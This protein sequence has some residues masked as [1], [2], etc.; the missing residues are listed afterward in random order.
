M[1][2]IKN[3]DWTPRPAPAII[4][5][6][7]ER[8]TS[9]AR[10]VVPRR[11][12][13]LVG[14]AGIGKSYLLARL[15]EAATREGKRV[16]TI[17]FPTPLADLT[18]RFALPPGSSVDHLARTLVARGGIVFVDCGPDGTLGSADGDR[19][20]AVLLLAR[21]AAENATV[22]AARRALPSASALGGIAAS[23]DAVY[24]VEPLGVPTN[25]APFSVACAA[26]S[27]A[28]FLRVHSSFSGGSAGGIPLDATSLRGIVSFVRAV[29]GFP[30]PI[31]A[32]ARRLAER[33]GG[34]AITERSPGWRGHGRTVAN[35]RPARDALEFAFDPDADAVRRAHEAALR[36]ALAR[37]SP[38][39]R[40]RLVALAPF[41]GGDAAA[42]EDGAARFAGLVQTLAD[43]RTRPLAS[44]RRVL[45]PDG[46][47]PAARAH[48]VTQIANRFENVGDASE[49]LRFDARLDGEVRDD[50]ERAFLWAQELELHERVAPLAIVVARMALGAGMA[51]D[52]VR[53]LEAAL[54][55]G[56][57]APTSSR[58]ASFHQLAPAIS[59][60]LG[61]ARIFRG[62]SAARNDLRNA[63]KEGDRH[64]QA[65][66]IAYRGLHEG[67]SDDANRGLALVQRAFARAAAPCPPA[68][69]GRILKNEANL[70]LEASRPAEL[71]LR[72][73]RACFSA[74]GDR[75]EIAF[76]DLIL[77][78]VLCDEGRF[79]EANE[80]ARAAL[81]VFRRLGDSR[82]EGRVRH[83][84]G[85][86]AADGGDVSAAQGH[87]DDAIDRFRAT[88]DRKSE[89]QSTASQAALAVER[90][91]LSAARVLVD[92]ALALFD[93]RDEPEQAL[94]WA[95]LG[96]L[97]ARSGR[98]S[99]AQI[100]FGRA[101]KCA[102]G[103]T[104]T[105][106]SDAVALFARIFDHPES[107][108]TA[109]A[110]RMKT[111][112]REEVRLAW[113]I[114]GG[115]AP[116]ASRAIEVASDGSF[117]RFP[118]GTNA[119][120]SR[121]PVL[122]RL[123]VALLDGRRHA[124]GSVI[125]FE[126]LLPFVWPDR[127]AGN[128]GNANRLYVAVKRLRAE[129]FNEAIASVPGGYRFADDPPIREI[130]PR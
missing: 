74:V 54:A 75:R 4:P 50:V 105:A 38:E 48:F 112:E 109:F 59:L 92:G 56:Q 57:T 86:L 124:P 65:L 8:P 110:A 53:V 125:S 80:A 77:A 67:L 31:V 99:A 85:I 2:G 46:I 40:Q 130:A 18:A 123:L 28:L 91:D 39:T 10:I 106:R 9:L 49:I 24:P 21:L 14:P 37:V 69:R 107:L 19:D 122:R 1:T 70:L 76:V 97:E 36:A 62:D 13:W 45:F 129:G 90:G 103:D 12:S 108:Q 6:L 68:V 27:V 51:F 116:A 101:R 23:P 15:V 60:L 42:A 22:V 96:Y 79:V 47:P 84:L 111:A 5:A 43:G 32:F 115:A 16:A 121:R 88:G 29:D 126:Q 127:S 78:T 113:R 81:D 73:A 87:F 63:E 117:V 33:T 94:S 128:A 61:V 55:F 30:G 71:V 83:V 41:D 98:P 52:A 102:R 119:D 26:P 44:L 17:V 118:D 34:E 93:G 72:E 100:A 3:G 66:A 82:S 114:L 89:G 104:R 7:N 58:R 95:L 120:F 11:T 64:L 35:A 20:D 25:D